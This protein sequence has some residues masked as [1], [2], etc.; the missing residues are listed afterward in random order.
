MILALHTGTPRC[1]LSVYRDE[2]WKASDWEAG[3]TLARQLLD[4]IEEAVGDIHVLTG[5]IV[6]Q[7]PGS[8]TGLRIGLTVANTLAESM[9]L[10]IVGV[11]GDQWRD[12]GLQRL[13]DGDNDLLVMPVYGSDPHITTPRK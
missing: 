10:P 13:Q 1:L 8:Y 3:R 9:N 4:H 7:G 6:F 2:Q 12:E 5:I 11:G